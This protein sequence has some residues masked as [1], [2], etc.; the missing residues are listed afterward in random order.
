MRN[1]HRNRQEDALLLTLNTNTRS[2]VR[3]YLI[4]MSTNCQ[5]LSI[6]NDS[7]FSTRSKRETSLNLNLLDTS[8]LT[9]YIG[10]TKY[11]IISYT[12]PSISIGIKSTYINIESRSLCCIKCKDNLLNRFIRRNGHCITCI[13]ADRSSR[14]I[15]CWIILTFSLTEGCCDTF[16]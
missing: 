11:N 12:C 6:V 2:I 13:H 15:V 14:I 1:L 16:S 10:H 8:L 7:I 9:A 5:I 3:N 4:G